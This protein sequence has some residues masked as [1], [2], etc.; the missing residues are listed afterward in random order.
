MGCGFFAGTHQDHIFASGSFS[1]SVCSDRNDGNRIRG[2]LVSTSE[3]VQ[4]PAR[5]RDEGAQA[6][7]LL[8]GAR[9]PAPCWY[10]ALLY[11]SAVIVEQIRNGF[12]GG[13]RGQMSV[14]ENPTYQAL[15]DY[16]RRRG[17]F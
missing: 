12:S 3:A 17:R 5:K 2:Y 10:V 11:S 4:R 13:N 15:S 8:M 1:Y 14:D 6:G 9:D 16:A 7:L